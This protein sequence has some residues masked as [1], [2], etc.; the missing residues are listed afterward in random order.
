MSADD[1]EALADLLWR[2]D[3]DSDRKECAGIAEAV[4]DAGFRRHSEGTTVTEQRL[5]CEGDPHPTVV[6]FEFGHDGGVRHSMEKAG[7]VIT[8]VEIR[9]RTRYADVVTEWEPVND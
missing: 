9:R 1:R 7:A 6:T 8:K 2:N 5:T 3:V 4:L